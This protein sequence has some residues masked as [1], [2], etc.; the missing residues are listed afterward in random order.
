MISW[1]STKYTLFH[2]PSNPSNVSKLGSKV[3]HRNEE[4]GF[5]SQADL[6]LSLAN[7]LLDVF[8]VK[9]VTVFLFV[10][11]LLFICSFV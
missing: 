2:L 7:T 5:E 6:G 10:F 8:F 3:Y 11:L 1:H 4:L 9:R